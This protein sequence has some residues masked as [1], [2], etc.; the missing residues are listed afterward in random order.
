LVSK[1]NHRWPSIYPLDDFGSQDYF[2]TL[3]KKHCIEALKMSDSSPF[4]LFITHCG[5]FLSEGRTIQKYFS[6]EM[7]NEHITYFDCI[8]M[9]F[10]F[11]MCEM[12]GCIKPILL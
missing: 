5:Q 11:K 10:N 2:H 1:T 3:L 9:Q 12:I 7:K 8:K 6:N 4:I